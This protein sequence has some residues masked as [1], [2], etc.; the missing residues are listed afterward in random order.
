MASSNQQDNPNILQPTID[1]SL[2]REFPEIGAMS[3]EDLQD[4]L[5]D[6]DFFHAMLIRQAE[7]KRL[8][9]EHQVAIERNQALAEKNL[10]LRPKLEELRDQV[11]SSFNQAQQA[12]SKFNHLLQ[13]QANLYQPYGESASRSR[14][15]TALHESDKLS[16]SLAHQFVVQGVLEEDQFIKEFR[17]ERTKYHKRAWVANHWLEGNFRWN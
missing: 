14:L 7:V 2:S 16:E 4:L 15:L 8:V 11:T 5:N 12:I 10:S 17:D 1:D 3:K 9:E 13:Q 6:P